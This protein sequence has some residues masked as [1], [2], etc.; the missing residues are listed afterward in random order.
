[1]DLKK[2]AAMQV[3]NVEIFVDNER[4]EWCQSEDDDL[5]VLI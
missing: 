5:Q 4:N 2:G 1:M 3:K